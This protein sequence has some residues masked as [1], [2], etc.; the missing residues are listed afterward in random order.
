MALWLGNVR[1]TV[2]RRLR[3]GGLAAAV[4]EER[5]YRTLADAGPDLRAALAA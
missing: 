5:L 2:H 1:A 4:G 3:R